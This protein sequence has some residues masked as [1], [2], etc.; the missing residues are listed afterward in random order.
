M[1]E[2]LK[3]AKIGAWF[4]KWRG[5]V[6]DEAGDSLVELALVLT[7]F[8]APLLV[9]T[10]E[11]G[12][13]VYDSIEVQNAAHTGAAYAMQSATFAANTSGIQTAAQADAPSFGTSMTVTPTVY[14]VCSS[15][16][17]GTQY[18]GS[19]ALATATGACTGSSNHPLE[20]VNVNTSVSVTPPLHCPGLA[21]SFALS[22]TS[23]MEIEQ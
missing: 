6:R 18:T 10:G 23:A 4:A 21:S 15:A 7:F 17:Q 16:L 19:G 22:G 1:R 3:A 11:M 2:S 12:M 13:L 9:G 5:L 8:C 14:Y 20:F